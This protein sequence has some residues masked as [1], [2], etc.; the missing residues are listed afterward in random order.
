MPVHSSM[1]KVD[2]RSAVCA[3]DDLKLRRQREMI[4][5]NPKSNKKTYLVV[6]PIRACPD[7]LT[8]LQI[9]GTTQEIAA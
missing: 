9:I 6:P 2:T 4:R 7:L 1:F 8:I 3:N 5:V